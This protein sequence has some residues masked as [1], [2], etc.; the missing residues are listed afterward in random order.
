MTRRTL[1]MLR[2]E[3]LYAL[4]DKQWR[5]FLEYQ[6][7]MTVVQAWHE[8]GMAQRFPEQGAEFSI[9]GVLVTQPH[10]QTLQPGDR[11]L[12]LRPLIAD[13]KEARRQR[14]LRASQAEAT[15]QHHQQKAQ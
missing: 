14:A 8:S 6:P 12:M 15:Q 11:M 10:E 1:K 5:V 3:L 7:A 4:A 9:S 2:V 13:P